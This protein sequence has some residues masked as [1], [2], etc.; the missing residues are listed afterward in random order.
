MAYATDIRSDARP[1]GIVA[2][3]AEFRAN[4]ADRRAKARVYRDTLAELRS[5]SDRDL[6]DLGIAPSNISFVA[7]EAAYGK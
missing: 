3:F 5:L 7:H 1:A 6:A 4:F 2:K